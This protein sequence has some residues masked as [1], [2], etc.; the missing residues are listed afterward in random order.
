MPRGVQPVPKP[1]VTGAFSFTIG[2]RRE[3]IDTDVPVYSSDF[4]GTHFAYQWTDGH[5]ELVYP[6]ADGYPSQY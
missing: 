4:A 6:P 3:T 2:L 5:S 1:H